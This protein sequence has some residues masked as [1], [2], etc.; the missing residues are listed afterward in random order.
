MAIERPSLYRSFGDKHRLFLTALDRYQERK[1][2]VLRGA[3]EGASSPRA[4]LEA[5]L[6]DTA[7][8]VACDP[9]ARGC[10]SVNS[11]MELAPG[12]L[13][14]TRRLQQYRDSVEALFGETLERAVAAGELPPDADTRALAR[15]LVV[16]IDGF[17]V[18][19]KTLPDASFARDALRVVLSALG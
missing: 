1:L 4:A 9:A 2:A 3:L 19:G 13:E 16:A 7:E 14:A 5:V 10:L 11:M 12:D 17:E 8:R 18:L 6:S 15:Y